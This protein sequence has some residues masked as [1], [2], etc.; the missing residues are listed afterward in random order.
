MKMEKARIFMKIKWNRLNRKVH[1]W[2][3]IVCAIPL[4]IVIGSG[5]LLLLKKEST[6]IQPATIKTQSTTPSI[7]FDEIFEVA[8]TVPE[9][10]IRQWKDIDRLDVRP[11]KGVIKIQSHNSWEIQIDPTT[12]AVLQVAFRRSDVIE[13]LHDGSYF[14]DNAKL[15]IFLPTALLLLILWITGV[16][17]FLLPYMKKKR[18][19][20]EKIR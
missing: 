7:S 20:S 4:L 10:E 8:K 2:G 15:M 3:A 16:Y 9:A 19:Y 13:S 11:N 14:H 6:W 1:Y 18:N 12:A 5:V 17:L